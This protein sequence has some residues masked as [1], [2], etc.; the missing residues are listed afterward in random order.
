[1]II[2]II[3][4]RISASVKCILR[5]IENVSLTL[6]KSPWPKE[7]DRNLWE[8]SVDQLDI[9]LE[10]YLTN[11]KARF[12][13]VPMKAMFSLEN[14]FYSSNENLENRNIS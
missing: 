10:G 14:N 8:D 6:N 3:I 5:D 1:M 11:L 4:N 2:S 13:P 7:K 9:D 12:G